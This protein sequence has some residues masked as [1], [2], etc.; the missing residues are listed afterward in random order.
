MWV[1]MRGGSKG[2]VKA[3][4]QY[5]QKREGDKGGSLAEQTQ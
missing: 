4:S 5:T 3:R 1:W 2:K